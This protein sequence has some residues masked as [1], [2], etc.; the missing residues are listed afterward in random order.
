L[1][2][3]P[4]FLSIQIPLW[5]PQKK[6]KTL[7]A[8]LILQCNVFKMVSHMKSNKDAK[9]AKNQMKMVFELILWENS[10]TKSDYPNGMSLKT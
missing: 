3:F 9:T 8:F 2:S 7:L 10:N 6:T 4:H 5:P 1:H